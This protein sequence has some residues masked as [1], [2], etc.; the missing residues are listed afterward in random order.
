MEQLA[1]SNIQH[2]N[3][4]DEGTATHVVTAVLYG[5]EAFFTFDREIES[6]ENY[7]DIHG[8]MEVV[9]KAIPGI[10]DIK[11][12]A[13]LDIGDQDKKEKD[14][15]QCKFYG[16]VV[17]KSNPSTFQDAVSV[18]KEL[19]KLFGKDEKNMVPK[20]VWLYPLRSLDS[21][22]AHMVREISTNLVSRTQK[23]IECLNN[24]VIRAHDLINSEV[25]D[26]FSGLKEQ[27]SRFLRNG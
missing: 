11:G 15:F 2:P 21:K 17:L 18:Y 1:R 22:A 8:N 24:M 7:R 12:S 4:F 20:K 13:D 26:C 19:P 3:V 25:Y 16:D 23:A 14:K 5:A 9:I 10:T 6:G 27:M